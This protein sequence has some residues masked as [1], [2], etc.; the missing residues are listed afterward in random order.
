VAESDEPGARERE[1][2]FLELLASHEGR[3][4]RIAGSYARGH[5]REDLFQEIL[6]QLW[7]ALPSYRGEAGL[8]TWAYRVALNTA[9][10]QLRQ[11]GRRPREVEPVEEPATPPAAADPARQDAILDE[12][13]GCLDEIDR[14]LLVLYLDGLSYQ[15]M[16][17][18]T[19]MTS[20]AVGVR[21]HRIKR[22]YSRRY[23]EP[24]T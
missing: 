13:L 8:G 18:V 3:L 23:L 20:S 7:R 22:A 10:S 6:V 24:A 11:R 4:R 9:L 21:L 14:S 5:E 16:S 19:G 2:A 12:F 15:Q 1:R 17:E